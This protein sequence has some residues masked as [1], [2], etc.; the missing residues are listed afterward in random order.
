MPYSVDIYFKCDT[1]GYD[2]WEKSLDEAT[3]TGWR[4][5]MTN[6]DCEDA[7]CKCRDCVRREGGEK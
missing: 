1:C 6:G 4:I 2:T 3:R 7:V 5:D